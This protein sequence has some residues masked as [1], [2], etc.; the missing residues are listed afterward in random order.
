[1]ILALFVY[2]LTITKKS[3]ENIVY[4]KKATNNGVFISATYRGHVRS[5]I[6]N[7]IYYFFA[8]AGFATATGRRPQQSTFIRLTICENPAK[9]TLLAAETNL[10]FNSIF[11]NIIAGGCV[12]ALA[13]GVRGSIFNDERKCLYLT[14]NS[15]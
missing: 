8:L 5:A 7:A 6:P 13:N 9:A 1:M 12:P 15:L 11:Y 4:C 14:I 2:T 10:Y 3:R